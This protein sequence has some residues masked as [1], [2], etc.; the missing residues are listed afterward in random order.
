MGVFCYF[1]L[2][3][4]HFCQQQPDGDGEGATYGIGGMNQIFYLPYW[5]PNLHA[6]FRLEVQFVRRLNVVEAVP[7]GL[8][9]HHAVDAV[10][11]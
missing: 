1:P 5:L 4:S 7:V 9:A 11:V 8:Q 3:L 2:Y 6:V 10:V